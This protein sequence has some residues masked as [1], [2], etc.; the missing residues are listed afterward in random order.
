MNLIWIAILALPGGPDGRSAVEGRA[1]PRPSI[2]EGSRSTDRF[3]ARSIALPRRAHRSPFSSP[4]TIS[5]IEEFGTEEVDETWF[6]QLEAAGLSASD[7][8]AWGLPR[9]TLGVDP[10]AGLDQPSR[11]KFPLRC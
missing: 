1:D 3:P 2:V 7:W 5:G 8:S 9:S 11:L 6:L 4:W 10:S